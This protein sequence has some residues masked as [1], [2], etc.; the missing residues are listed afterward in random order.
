MKSGL[1]VIID[2][3]HFN[4]I[5]EWR[6]RDLA[7]E[8]A[9]RFQIVSFTDVSINE[10]IRRDQKRP[11][12]VGQD[13]I[14]RMDDYR[15]SLTRRVVADLKKQWTAKKLAAA[16]PLAAKENAIVKKAAVGKAAAKKMVGKADQI[17]NA[18]PAKKTGNCV[19]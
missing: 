18:I 6:Y 17:A 3:T 16:K 2:N 19:R 15:A 8:Y 7:E 10:C 5:H 1:N 14:V 12:W 11:K 9:Y 13:V 4:P